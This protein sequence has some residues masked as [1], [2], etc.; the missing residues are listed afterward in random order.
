MYKVIT[1]ELTRNINP[2]NLTGHR[3]RVCCVGKNKMNDMKLVKISKNE[4]RQIWEAWHYLN[5]VLEAC[6][7][8]KKQIEPLQKCMST[9][10]GL[11]KKIKIS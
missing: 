5:N 7:G 2:P 4:E 6:T 1:M 3:R 10:I 9:L 8:D 11:H